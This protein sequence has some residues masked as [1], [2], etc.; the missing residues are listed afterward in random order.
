M[1]TF[2]YLLYWTIHSLHKFEIKES[3]HNSFWRIIKQVIKI[4][5]TSRWHRWKP[6]SRAECLLLFLCLSYATV[7]VTWCTFLFIFVEMI[8]ES[9]HDKLIR[10]EISMFSSRLGLWILNFCFKT[11]NS[12]PSVLPDIVLKKKYLFNFEEYQS[13]NLF[14]QNHIHVIWNLQLII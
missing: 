3:Q 12:T 1:S 8:I 14:C 11:L 9:V 13:S 10:N 6:C 4:T 5:N 2:Y 7:L